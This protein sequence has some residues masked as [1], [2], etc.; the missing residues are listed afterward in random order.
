MH[1]AEDTIREMYA[2]L[3]TV[4][5]SAPIYNLVY[6]VDILSWFNFDTIKPLIK[7]DV[8]NFAL[9]LMSKIRINW[10]EEIKER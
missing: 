9:Y 4:A 1:I 5:E 3:D 2:I 10:Q 7:M 6:D 8:L